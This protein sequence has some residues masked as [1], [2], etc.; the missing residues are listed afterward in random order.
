MT[1][2]VAMSASLSLASRASAAV[3]GGGLG[4]PEHV[5]VSY[6]APVWRCVV[7]LGQVRGPCVLAA[8]GCLVALQKL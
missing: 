1:C 5:Q 2:M 3:P 8:A 6:L 7:V 4:G